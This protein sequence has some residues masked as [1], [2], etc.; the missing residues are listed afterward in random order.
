L[1]G[2]ES[3]LIQTISWEPIEGAVQYRMVIRDDTIG[4]ITN[5]DIISENSYKFDWGERDVQNSIRF[6]TQYKAEIDGDWIDME[7]YRYI[8]A[9]GSSVLREIFGMSFT[10][11]SSGGLAVTEAGNRLFSLDKM[12]ELDEHFAKESEVPE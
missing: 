7:S 10:S 6:R 1:A 11:D 4:E 8:F 12:K 2:E 5:K 9:P 3:E